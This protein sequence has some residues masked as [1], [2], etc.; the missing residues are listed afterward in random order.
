MSF[1][2]IKNGYESFQSYLLF[3]LGLGGGHLM[4]KES[5]FRVI[6]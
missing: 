3:L 2:L 5:N 1:E 6:Y 4:Q